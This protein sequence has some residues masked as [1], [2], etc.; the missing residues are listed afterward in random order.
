MPARLTAQGTVYIMRLLRKAKECGS[1]TLV[2][3]AYDDVMSLPD[4]GSTARQCKEAALNAAL[5]HWR[6]EHRDIEEQI[7]VGA[8]P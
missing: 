8:S 7:M 2:L 4:T 6:Q 5:T 1:C 3:R